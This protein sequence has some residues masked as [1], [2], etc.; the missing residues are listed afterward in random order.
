MRSYFFELIEADIELYIVQLYLAVSI[1][2]LES[3][4]T[5]LNIT[6]LSYYFALPIRFFQCLF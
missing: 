2:W 3:L 6:L 5:L 4:A 1:L